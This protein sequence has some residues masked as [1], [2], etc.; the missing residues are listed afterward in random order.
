LD[1]ALSLILVNPKGHCKE[2][3]RRA[4]SSGGAG[5]GAA[6]FDPILYLEAKGTHSEMYAMYSLEHIQVT[7]TLTVQE[8][9]DFPACFILA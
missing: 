8:G 1:E 3:L 2:L 7:F 9:T 5:G 6:G 4:G